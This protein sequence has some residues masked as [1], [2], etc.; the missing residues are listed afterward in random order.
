MS[1][2]SYT[3]EGRFVLI[4]VPDLSGARMTLATGRPI[5]DAVDMDVDRG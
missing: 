1:Y 4:E 3:L 2:D 5:S